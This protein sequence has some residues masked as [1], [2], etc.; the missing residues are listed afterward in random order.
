MKLL[1]AALAAAGLTGC[2]GYVPYYD[3]GAYPGYGAAPLDPAYGA[4][5]V[6]PAYP[7][8][9]GYPYYGPSISFGAF[10]GGGYGHRR[11]WGG[12]R[13]WNGNRGHWD[14]RRWH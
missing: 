2:V 13:G 8:S 12:G 4:A 5:Q 1:I 7:Y 10:F 3:G 6:Y 9:Y 14:G 11:H